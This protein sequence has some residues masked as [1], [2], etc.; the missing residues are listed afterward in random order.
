MALEIDGA[1]SFSLENIEQELNCT[2]PKY[3]KNLLTMT[4]HNTRLSFE[5][6]SDDIIKEMELFAKE[7]LPKLIDERTVEYFGIF[8]RNVALFKIVGGDKL[9]LFHI[10]KFIKAKNREKR[11]VNANQNVMVLQNPARSTQNRNFVFNNSSSISCGSISTASSSND[12][13]DHEEPE[14]INLMKERQIVLQ[15]VNSLYDGLAKKH[16]LVSREEG[17]KF[18]I[19]V[20]PAVR[21]DAVAIAKIQCIC[22]ASSTVHLVKDH[23]KV[24]WVLSNFNK[25]LTQVH[26]KRLQNQKNKEQTP[27]KILKN[28][29]I[30]NYFTS[31]SLNNSEQTETSVENVVENLTAVENIRASMSLHKDQSKWIKPTYTRDSRRKRNRQK[32]LTKE[33]TVVTDFYPILENIQEILSKNVELVT[34]IREQLEIGTRTENVTGNAVLFWDCSVSKEKNIQHVL[35]QIHLTAEAN[36]EKKPGANRFEKTLKLFCTYLF[37]I[38]GRLLYETLY[39]N[40]KNAL[41]SLSTIR[42]CMDDQKTIGEGEM[43][44]SE[45]RD[46]LEKRNYPLHVFISEDQTR[47]TG[48]ISYNSKTNSLIGFV[49]PPSTNGLPTKNSYIATDP[50][51]MEYFFLNSSRS[52]NAYVII[53]QPLV[54]KAP[55]FCLAVYGSDN[56]FLYTDILKRWKAMEEL[57]ESAGIKIE[58][59]SSD[60]DSRLLKSMKIR[61]E[62]PKFGPDENFPF[63]WYNVSFKK[64]QPVFIQDAVHIGTKL[65]NRILKPSIIL[66]IGNYL[67][68]VQHLNQLLDVVSK[69]KHL[70][71][72]NDLNPK[73]RMNYTSVEKISSN[74]VKSLLSKHVPGSNATVLYLSLVRHI[75]NAFLDKDIAVVDRVYSIW[76]SVFI[77]RMW[78][79]WLQKHLKYNIKNNFISMNAYVC[80][81]LNAHELIKVIEKFK[82]NQTEILFLPWL[83]SS[84]PCEKTFRAIRSLTST[85]STVVNFNML[86]ILQRLNRIQLINEIQSDTGKH[87]VLM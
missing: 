69:D 62:M 48:R 38:G 67:V 57:A 82:E 61:V 30:T 55:S 2:L 3:L 18:D 35:K 87:I 14:G 81:E 20:E 65:R 84:Q 78:K 36:G 59:F 63:N 85:Y 68:S 27:Q 5:N 13:G 71:T 8:Y 54:D 9:L 31:N 56:K 10:S 75:I 25:H 16:M 73:D 79:Y 58:G 64:N 29:S 76:F 32:S 60:G 21:G 7:D 34:V 41:P 28:T 42:R 52:T 33:Q 72:H 83:M 50:K 39:A 26:C 45:L 24:K 22:S 40:M 1:P 86:E 37:L 77:L 12:I 53:A 49:L 66:P 44:F 23:N 80:I 51:S 6:M 47:I 17:S 70:L 19:Q 15:R 4:G 46:F 11:G 74:L 43:R